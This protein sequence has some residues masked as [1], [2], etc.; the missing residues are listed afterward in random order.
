MNERARQSCAKGRRIGAWAL[1]A[2]LGVVTLVPAQA[3][4]TTA[5]KA[6]AAFLYQFGS[7]VEW[8][9]QA[10]S[11]PAFTIAV[12]GAPSIVEELRRIAPGRTLQGRPV[13][14]RS[15]ESMNDV[16]DAQILF[17]G[18]Q[19]VGHLSR[20]VEAIRRRPV[21]LV[22]E[23]NG[24]LGK[25]ATINFT[26]VD[27]RVRF[28]VSLSAAARSGLE[29][30]SRLLAIAFS[31]ERNGQVLDTIPEEYASVHASRHSPSQSR[32]GV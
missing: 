28:E 15:V 13:Q 31:V 5:D 7:F 29:L 27:E 24:A 4:Q 20:I 19:H 10:Q 8:P 30:S 3:Q 12:Y 26:I 22:A 9:P 14:V 25:G 32:G 21:L 23:S 1:L 11:A 16:E 6:K 2:F 17:V 18:E